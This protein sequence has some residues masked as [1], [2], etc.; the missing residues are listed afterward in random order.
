M[1]I[2]RHHVGSTENCEGE[3]Q[4]LVFESALPARPVLATDLGNCVPLPETEFGHSLSNPQLVFIFGLV[5]TSRTPALPV[6]PLGK[7]RLLVL[8][9]ATCNLSRQWLCIR[10]NRLKNEFDITAKPHPRNSAFPLPARWSPHHRSQNTGLEPQQVT[11]GPEENW[12]QPLSAG[13]CLRP[14]LSLSLP[15]Q[16]LEAYLASQSY[17]LRPRPW[18]LPSYKVRNQRILHALTVSSCSGVKSPPSAPSY[19][20][21]RQ[22]VCWSGA[23]AVA[24][25]SLTPILRFRANLP[26]LSRKG[27]VLSG[28][29]GRSGA[30]PGNLRALGGGS[31]GAASHQGRARP[32]LGLHTQRPHGPGRSLSKRVCAPGGAWSPFGLQVSF[33]G[34]FWTNRWASLPGRAVGLGWEAARLA[35]VTVGGGSGALGCGGGGGGGWLSVGRPRR[36]AAPGPLSEGSS[37]AKPWRAEGWRADGRIHIQ[38]LEAGGDKESPKLMQ[39]SWKSGKEAS[40]RSALQS[41]GCREGWVL[42]PFVQALKYSPQF[43]LRGEVGGRGSAW[44]RLCVYFQFVLASGRTGCDSCS[45]V[46]SRI[47]HLYLEMRGKALF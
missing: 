5:K 33:L 20:T 19:P 25:P 15:S 24:A 31:P 36:A 17:W 46:F 21:T 45:K 14:E 3:A 6:H 34:A 39:V 28:C 11:W 41:P 38:N 10:I 13:R 35:P 29:R 42:V 32:A 47:C 1:Q 23:H 40:K 7:R 8:G 37:G 44:T 12:T 16:L 30:F 43:P 22:V 9:M 27:S 2:L 18:H 4:W 26:L